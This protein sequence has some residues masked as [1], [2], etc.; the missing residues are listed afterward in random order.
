MSTTLQDIFGG[1]FDPNQHEPASD[2]DV[3]PAGKYP[4][5]IEKAELKP[6]KKGN[7]HYLELQM[8]VL[9]GPCKNRKLWDRLNLDNPSEVARKIASGVLTA[10]VQAVGLPK[11]KSWDELIGKY[12]LASVR[13]KDEQNEIR[14][15]KSVNEAAAQAPAAQAPATQPNAPASDPGPQNA[16][17]PNGTPPWMQGKAS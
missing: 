8:V 14:T 10:L 5:E 3:L 17:L 16:D 9:D 6:T 1:D 2:F 13:V 11:L 12:A 4:V 7:G 15:Y